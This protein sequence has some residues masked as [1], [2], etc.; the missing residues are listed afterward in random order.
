MYDRFNAKTLA[1]TKQIKQISFA[2]NWSR[3]VVFT[4]GSQTTLNFMMEKKK[5]VKKLPYS[6]L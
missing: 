5:V 6:F 4:A 3:S 2:T 1:A